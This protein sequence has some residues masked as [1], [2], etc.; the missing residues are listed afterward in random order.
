MLLENRLAAQKKCIPL[1]FGKSWSLLRVTFF[2]FLKRIEFKR[3][4]FFTIIVILLLQFLSPDHHVAGK[5]SLFKSCELD[6]HFLL[7]PR[8]LD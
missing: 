8:S 6:Q 1:R 2:F 5:W 7:P 3:Q 4:F